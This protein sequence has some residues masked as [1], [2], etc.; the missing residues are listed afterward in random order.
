MDDRNVPQEIV[1]DLMTDPDKDAGGRTSPA[2]PQTV[3]AEPD[4]SDDR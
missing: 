4:A 3:E 1:D 2:P